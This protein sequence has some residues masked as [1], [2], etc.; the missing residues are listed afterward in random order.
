MGGPFSVT[1]SDIYMDKMED[2]IV[3]KHQPKFYKRYVDDI[4]NPCKKNQVDLLFNDLI[5]FNPCKKNQVDLLFNDLNNYHQS[6]KVTLELN[7]KRF[8]DT[9]LEFQNGIL[10]TSVHRKETKLPTP[11]NSK[12]PKKYKRNLIIGY[13]HRSK[14]ISTDFTKEKNI[15]K[16][17]FKKVD[18]PTKFI[19]SVIKRFEYNERN[20]DQ[21][22]D[23]IIPPYLYEEPKPRIMVEFPFCELNVKRISTFRKRFN[24]FTNDSYYF[25]V[26]WKT[27]KVKSFF[28]LKDKNL[29]PSC[30]VYY[31]LCSYG[32]DYVGETKRNV[33]V[34]YDEHNKLS[35][36][37][38]PV[39]HLEQKIGDHF[40]RRILC[41]AP[42]C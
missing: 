22:D 3:E 38:K 31:G 2:E 42:S 34:S 27:T 26:V 18:F 20:K 39:E 9:N 33:S 12:I 40:T 37:L 13:L 6:I 36:K 10:I 28:P 1:L 8:L 11:W 7:P 32:E 4:V 5:N 41:N 25:N 29:Y 19:D 16:N 21:Q 15:F 35:K 23:F 30:K 24:Y 17:K 14:R